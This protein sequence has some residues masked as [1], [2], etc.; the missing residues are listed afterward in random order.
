[1]SK[2]QQFNRRNFIRNTTTAAAGL[3]LLPTLPVEASTEKVIY[4]PAADIPAKQIA[5]R[6]RFSVIGINHSH[7]N[8]MVDAVTRGGG[9]LISFYAKEPDLTAAFA[10]KFPQ[11]KLAGSENEILEDPSIQLI[12][13]SGIP[14]DRAPLGIRVMKHGKDYLSDKPGAITLAQLAE[15]RK[16]QKE[17]KRIYSI[18]YSERFESKATVKAG[19]LAKAGAIGK[20]IQT[21][22]IAPHKMTPKSRPEWFFDPQY[23][24]G[25]LTDI[26][27]HQF[28]QYLYFTGT[29]KAQ[30]VASQI[31]NVNHPQ[32]PKIQDFGDVMLRGN[33]G[34]GYI[35]LDWFTP[36]AIPTFGDGRL[37]ILGTEGYIEVRKTLDIAGRPG[38]DHLF[39]ANQKE[40]RYI[41]C[42][43]DYLPFGEQLINDIL[44]RT[45][46]A[47]P[48]EHCFLATELALLAQK[49]AQRID[50][51]L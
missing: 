47:M 26:G 17:T 28:D 8:G 15:V 6:L 41:D 12:L 34:M 46:T 3:M 11:A 2:K 42:S 13:S 4:E 38:G 7:I 51:M 27:S 35:R 45:E 18:M 25:I 22:N 37:T 31:G 48:Q 9:Q 16:V 30:I 10:K 44:N 24:G 40:I 19:E 5:T 1:M 43:K 49:N 39:I 32:Y 29:T 33:G 50:L 36:D 23:C 14:V 20:V 21:I